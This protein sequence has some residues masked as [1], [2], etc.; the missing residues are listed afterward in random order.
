MQLFPVSCTVNE[1][2]LYHS[3]MLASSVELYV[4]DLRA[5]YLGKHQSEWLT[6]GLMTSQAQ[7]KIIITGAPLCSVS[8][9]ACTPLINFAKSE[10]VPEEGDD[11]ISNDKVTTPK[12]EHRVSITIEEP[13]ERT[14]K[15]SLSSVLT[16]VAQLRADAAL[17]PLVDGATLITEPNAIS[18]G[19]VVLSGGKS[20]STA[21]AVAPYVAG[22]SPSIS[23]ND[24]ALGVFA[25][26]VHV[27][28]SARPVMPTYEDPLMKTHPEL[29]AD[30]LWEQAQGMDGN[31]G[32][33][34]FMEEDSLAIELINLELQTSFSDADMLSGEAQLIR[35][36]VS[37]YSNRFISGAYRDFNA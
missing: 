1:R 14:E 17:D 22:F 27:G 32:C 34:V 19:I 13:E 20:K 9:E 37:L 10:L 4:L 31:V 23:L 35:S 3:E 33:K 6:V 21:A 30:I 12:L 29:N 7:W 24:K 36:S 25:V 5:G 18:S 28:T 15:Y 16:A 2:Q 26:E 8:V 11:Y